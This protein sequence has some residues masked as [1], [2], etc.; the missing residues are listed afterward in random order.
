MTRREIRSG[1]R[2]RGE[3]R[4]PGSKSVTN[5]YLNLA[6]LTRRPVLIE[7]PLLADDTRAFLAALRSTG[8]TVSGTA[9]AIS[10][11]NG[12]ATDQGTVFCAAS[13]TMLRFAT[14]ALSTT[15]GVWTVD[16]GRRL[17]ERP[18]GDLVNALRAQGA[19]ITYLGAT[20]F[21]PLRI[22]GR[23]L[24]G[25]RVV[26][27][28][29]ASSQYVSALMMAALK[30]RTK[31]VIEV[32]SLVSAP[33]IEITTRCIRE[34]GGRVES[35][36][37]GVVEVAPA[38]LCGGRYTV[39]GD[40]SSACYLAAAAA[41]TGGRVA[42]DGLSKDSVQGDRRFLDV[43]ASMG[44]SVTW[45]NEYVEISGD[46][47]LAA[48]DLDMS[49]MPDQVPTLAALAPFALGTTRIR[50][51]PHL[52]IKESDRI[53]SVAAGLRAAGAVA[54]ELEDGLEIVGVWG[55]RPPPTGPVVIDT[56]DDHRI[57]MSF[58]VLGLAR[59]GV[60]IE[61]PDVVEKSFPDF[62]NVFARC[63]EADG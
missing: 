39:E 32:R 1:A 33:Y 63:C 23:G 60:E 50:G 47:P 2:A 45:R 61:H 34:W 19:R 8:M 27:T 48:V 22:H 26:V 59:G 18:V 53:A 35:R 11:A 4:I 6:L 31:T 25:G 43:L 20:G 52:R 55:N 28:A 58:A 7:R 49:D 16:G 42:L 46:P 10:I 51:V 57:A 9:R 13:G 3:A 36:P 44:A 5:R 56:A 15:S 37:D 14:A 30:A 29:G 38:K 17:R 40:Y 21:A 54:K 62:W 41:L 12:P 24:A